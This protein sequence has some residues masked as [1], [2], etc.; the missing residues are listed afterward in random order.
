MEFEAR[1]V[2]IYAHFIESGSCCFSAYMCL[3]N[4]LHAW[5]HAQVSGR[6]NRCRIFFNT[7]SLNVF[8]LNG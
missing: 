7:I 8:S 5:F 6:V 4:G 3:I 2:S 1:L